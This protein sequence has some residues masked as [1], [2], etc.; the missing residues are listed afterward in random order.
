MVVAIALVQSQPA[1]APSV[2]MP[3]KETSAPENDIEELTTQIESAAGAL[4]KTPGNESVRKSL[5]LDYQQRAEQLYAEGREALALEDIER[6]VDIDPAQT[7]A[8]VLRGDILINQSRPDFLGAIA[9]YTQALSNSQ[10][11][12]S[13]AASVLGKRCRA[14]MALKDWASA[15]ADCTQSLS[16][17][18]TN[19][20]IYADRGDIYAAQSEFDKATQQYDTAIAMNKKSGIDDRSL[21]Y[22][23]SQAREKLDDIEGALL[24]L[25]HIKTPQ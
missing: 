11:S 14:H 9:A 25:Q 3:L 18:A 21:Y 15:D 10:I 22:R 4:T 1:A 6:S 16:L 20:D 13:K 23:R 7:D 2:E 17:N 8:F 24:D 5:A 12:D 19:A